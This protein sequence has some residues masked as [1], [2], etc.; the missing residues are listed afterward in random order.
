MV[1]T[2]YNSIVDAYDE[3]NFESASDPA[4]AKRSLLERLQEAVQEAKAAVD[5]AKIDAALAKERADLAQKEAEGWINRQVTDRSHR[6]SHPSRGLSLGTI[7][8]LPEQD[9]P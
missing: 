1:T 9:V 3:T 7:L 8:R 5:E 2:D 6:K 4:P